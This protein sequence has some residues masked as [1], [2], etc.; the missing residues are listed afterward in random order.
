MPANQRLGPHNLPALDIDLWLVK[1]LK[2]LMLERMTQFHLKLQETLRLMDSRVSDPASVAALFL[3][4]IA[5]MVRGADQHLGL[6]TMHRRDGDANARADCDL[7]RFVNEWLLKRREDP[8]SH[9]PSARVSETWEQQHEFIR[10]AS[11]QNGTYRQGSFDPPR[12]IAQHS[13]ALLFTKRLVDASK[14]IEVNHSDGRFAV[15]RT[16]SQRLGQDGEKPVPV[17]KARKLIEFGQSAPLTKHRDS[18]GHGAKRNS[19]QSSQHEL[20]DEDQ[21]LLRPIR[22]KENQLVNFSE[23]LHRRRRDLVQVAAAA[24]VLVGQLHAV[25]P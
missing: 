8:L 1:Q 12:H 7:A 24:R 4:R 25:E 23:R 5:S 11:R 2:F 3:R 6:A 18:E 20:A 21:M 9:L 16:S 19:S 22:Q 15:L 10:R 17:R 13:I 14:A